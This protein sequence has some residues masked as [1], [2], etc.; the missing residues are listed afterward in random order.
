MSN[1]RRLQRKSY[2]HDFQ[3]FFVSVRLCSID[4]F[5]QSDWISKK[6][7]EQQLGACERVF[8]DRISFSGSGTKLERLS[9]ERPFAV[10][11]D[12]LCLCIQFPP[13]NVTVL[14]KQYNKEAPQP[15]PILSIQPTSP[16]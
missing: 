14:S 15:Y 6:Y 12:V 16:F 3:V 10:K 5:D 7:G 4:T 9:V 1:L 8:V 11:K 2:L 13:F